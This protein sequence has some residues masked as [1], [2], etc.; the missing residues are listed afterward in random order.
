MAT[1]Y[2][3]SRA[4]EL[5][6]SAGDDKIYG[7]GGNDIILAWAGSGQDTDVIAGGAGDDTI[8]ADVSRRSKL[9]GDAGN[10]RISNFVD[11]DENGG[12]GW[13]YGGT[14]N[15]TINGNGYLSGDAGNDV[16]HGGWDA[17]NTILGGA[18]DD[19]LDGNGTLNGGAGRDT[20]SNNVYGGLDT[21]MTGG[22]QAD[23]FNVNF[24]DGTFEYHAR[25]KVTITDFRHSE[26]DKLDL[27]SMH[28]DGED[29]PYWNV[30]YNNN[31]DL[32]AT[33][34]ADKNGNRDGVIR[35]GDFA[36]SRSADGDL[37]LRYFGSMVELD[38]VRSISTADW[39]H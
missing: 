20:L 2:G 38:G 6:G 10:D 39:I 13:I 25:T 27:N 1:I 22:T 21:K 18:G 19:K 4:D 17:A 29:G 3:T 34:D 26:G 36:T 14:G 32:F 11:A 30:Y 23:R 24:D 37:Q 35:I 28:L 9:F 8:D 7:Y 5:Y 12:G 33:F 31:F 15:D 16:V